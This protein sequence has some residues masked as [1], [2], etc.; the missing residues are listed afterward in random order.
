M[1][2]ITIEKKILL[3]LFLLLFI[4]SGLNALSNSDKRQK[5]INVLQRKFNIRKGLSSALIIGTSIIQIILPFLI[6]IFL[7]YFQKDEIFHMGFYF[8]MFFLFVVTQI[9]YIKK[10]IPLLTNLSLLSALIYIYRDLST[11]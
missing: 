5:K 1:N 7:F 11:V 10:P 3:S 2:K 6:I 4:F 8:L 9:Y